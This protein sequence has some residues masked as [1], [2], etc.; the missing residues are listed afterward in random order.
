MDAAFSAVRVT[1]FRVHD[2]GFDQVFI[3]VV[4]H[5]EAA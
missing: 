2:A 5:V 1:F 4:G 3:F